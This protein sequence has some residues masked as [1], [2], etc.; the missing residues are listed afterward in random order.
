[1]SGES[2]CRTFTVGKHHHLTLVADTWGDPAAEPILFAHGGGQT[3][4]AWGQT[5]RLLAEQGFYTLALDLRGHGDSSWDPGEDYSFQDYA[6]DLQSVADQLG[7]K[8][9]AVGASLGGISSLIAH[10]VSRHQLFSKIVLVDITPRVELSGLGRIRD[11]ML[12]HAETGFASP[13]E[14]A[15]YVAAY[16][17]NRRRGA[18]AEG[19]KKNLRLG[20]DGRYRWHWDPKFFAAR[21]DQKRAGHARFELMEEAARALTIPALLVRGR[22]SDLVSPEGAR[23]FLELVPHARFVDI[24]EAGHMV[25]GDKNDIFSGAVIEFLCTASRKSRTGA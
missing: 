18:N 5:A 24:E 4:H 25:A 23:E 9:M 17:P 11:F 20:A 14:A 8:P 1:M 19:L 16:T 3:R 15:E 2:V 22:I 13:Q 6:A 12:E 21:P 7:R 10:H